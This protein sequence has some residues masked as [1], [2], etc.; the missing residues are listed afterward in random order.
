MYKYL[1]PL[2]PEIIGEKGIKYILLLSFIYNY[3]YYE[4]VRR[5]LRKNKIQFLFHLSYL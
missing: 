3:I 4:T 2:F 5:G 1:Q